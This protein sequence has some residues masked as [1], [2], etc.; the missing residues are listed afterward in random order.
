MARQ[1]HDRRVDGALIAGQEGVADAREVFSAG[2]LSQ[3]FRLI[4]VDFPERHVLG[5][6]F[7]AL[8]G[9]RIVVELE[10]PWSAQLGG[11]EHQ[12]SDAG[13]SI[14]PSR[15]SP[16]TESRSADGAAAVGLDSHSDSDNV[17]PPS[18]RGRAWSTL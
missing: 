15:H 8:L 12:D 13:R 2:G 9:S 6:G 17:C 4:D 7:V 3:L 5:A 14:S 11:Q 1:V 16:W 10:L 18:E